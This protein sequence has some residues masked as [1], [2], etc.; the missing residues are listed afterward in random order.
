MTKTARKPPS[1]ISV[2]VTLRRIRP[3]IW[4]RLVVSDDSTLS[5]LHVAIQAAM[6]WESAHLWFFDVGGK[7]FGDPSLLPEVDDDDMLITLKKIQKAGTTRFTYV[8]DL[9]DNWQHTVVIEKTVPKAGLAATPT[10][11]GGKRNCPPEDCG[12]IVGYE[13]L[14]MASAEPNSDRYRRWTEMIG[15]AF[16]PEQFSVE[17]ADNRV[18]GRP[19][20]K[21]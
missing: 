21:E 11:V 1:L 3:P 12:G 7:H 15:K 16:K 2:K 5:D 10:C 4:R 9:G 18:A 17:E 8:Y 20:R 6:G 14:L 19:H 13:Q